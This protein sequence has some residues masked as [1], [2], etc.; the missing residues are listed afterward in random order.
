MNEIGRS[1]EKGIH[2]IDK[3]SVG[4]QVGGRVSI[5]NTRV[6]WGGFKGWGPGKT[7][8][9]REQLGQERFCVKLN[10]QPQERSGELRDFTS[11]VPGRRLKRGTLEETTGGTR[12]PNCMRNLVLNDRKS[13]RYWKWANNAYRRG[14]P[15]KDGKPKNP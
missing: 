14:T 10:D 11:P 2:G 5:Q 9:G 1:S 13:L 3:S 15:G 12:I 7:E 6:V 8:G 4:F